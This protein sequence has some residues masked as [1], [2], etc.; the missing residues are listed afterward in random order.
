MQQRRPA[1]RARA[2]AAARARRSGR[3]RSAAASMRCTK[4]GSISEHDAAKQ[5]SAQREGERAEGDEQADF[6]RAQALGRIGAIA[7]DRARK[8]GGA[9]IVGERVGGEGDQADE[10]PAR[11]AAEMHRA[12]SGRTRR[13]PHRRARAEATAKQPVRARRCARALA[14]MSARLRPLQLAQQQPTATNR[15]R[16]GRSTGQSASMTRFIR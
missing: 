3:S 5:Q 8:H 4:L 7:H 10:P 15:P 16:R 11:A 14:A 2:E 13:A 6:R 1:Y 12:R 9:D